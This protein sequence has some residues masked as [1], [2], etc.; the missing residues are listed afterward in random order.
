M[1]E[2]TNKKDHWE[3]VYQKKSPVEVSWYQKVPVLSLQLTIRL[4]KK[5]SDRIVDVGGGASTLAD[6]LLDKGFDDITVLDL[7]SEALAHAQKRL[8]QKSAQISWVAA[9]ITEWEPS[10]TFE[11][12]HDRAVYHFL[13]EK[14]DREKYKDVLKRAT[15]PGSWVIIAAF[16]IGGPEK[17]SGL[18]IVQYDREKLQSE[19]GD[20]FTF[21]EEQFESHITPTGKE[22]AFGYFVFERQ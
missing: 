13:T 15:H 17:C 18:D 12:W 20:S 2:A 5:K 21:V 4:L 22:Q 11:L 6:H 8:G 7:S 3:A 19:L 10:G 1:S 9:D 14:T 16:S